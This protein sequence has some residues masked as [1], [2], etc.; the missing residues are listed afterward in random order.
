[1]KI[2]EKR[3]VSVINSGE[4]LEYYMGVP[5]KEGIYPLVVLLHG[6][7]SRGKDIGA[8]KTHSM[9]EPFISGVSEKA[10]F[11]MPLCEWNSWYDI[12]NMLNE[13]VDSARHF[14][15]V[16]INRV[17]ITGYSMGGYTAWTLLG[18]HPDWYA[19]GIPICGGSQYSG[20]WAGTALKNTP[21][22]AFH[23][24]LD[25]TVA[26]E[27][28]IKVVKGINKAG[29]D[30]KLTVYEKVKH[31]AWINAYNSKETWDWLFDKKRS[32]EDK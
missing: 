9:W 18:M 27:E 12:I 28:T 6:A 10:I 17:Y 15:N 5:E 22:W 31:D 14:D 32:K 29:G 19:A 20:F 25:E 11:V 7:G 24:L 1:M 2:I 26:V 3:F 23:G 13:F 4:S 21:I 8:L 30:A 16:D